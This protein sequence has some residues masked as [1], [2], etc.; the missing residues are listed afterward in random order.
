MILL[1]AGA[2]NIIGCDRVGIIEPGRSDLNAPKRWYAELTNPQGVRRTL[3]DALRDADLF[4]G[5]SGPN[6]LV[7]ADLELMAPDPIVFAMAN[8]VPEIMPEE[9]AGQVRVMATGRSDYP[10]QIN[11]VPCF[12]G[13]FR[14]ALDA[15]ARDITE[16]MNVAAAHAIA[17][18]IPDESLM[19]EY[20]IPSVFDERVAPAVAAAVMQAAVEDGVAR[21]G[22]DQV[23]QEPVA[24]FLS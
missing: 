3:R 18:V 7:A 17:D 9:A 12:P 10:S 6:A 2:R 16:R 19:E 5:L 1:A 22:T 21:R 24:P 15:R 4:L 20:I 14:G 23:G 13:M 11:N 8:P